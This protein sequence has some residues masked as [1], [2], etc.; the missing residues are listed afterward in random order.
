MVDNGKDRKDDEV[1]VGDCRMGSAVIGW[2][3]QLS[4][5]LTIVDATLRG[6][7]TPDAGIG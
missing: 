7:G 3:R 5:G 4:D 1:G 2:A 6:P